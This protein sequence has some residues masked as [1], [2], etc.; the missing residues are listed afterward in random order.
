MTVFGIVVRNQGGASM[1]GIH[2][3]EPT[4]TTSLLAYLA[5]AIDET[6]LVRSLDQLRD[7]A[8]H[9]REST[10]FSK[11]LVCLNREISCLEKKIENIRNQVK[12]G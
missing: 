8:R 12:R 6:K 10:P 9:E 4:S 2:Q 5:L 11:R 7:Q 3:I 1:K